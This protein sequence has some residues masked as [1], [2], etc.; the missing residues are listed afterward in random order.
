MIEENMGPEIEGAMTQVPADE[1][2]HQGEI[3]S[4]TGRDGQ[5]KTGTKEDKKRYI[6]ELEQ[7]K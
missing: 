2:E 7:E 5:I 3:E 4:W 6:E 1:K